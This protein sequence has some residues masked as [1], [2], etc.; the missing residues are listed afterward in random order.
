MSYTS[1]TLFLEG[2]SCAPMNITQAS[3]QNCKPVLAGTTLSEEHRSLSI[4]GCMSAKQGTNL[5]E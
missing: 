4:H 1:K 2:G 5:H 3:T